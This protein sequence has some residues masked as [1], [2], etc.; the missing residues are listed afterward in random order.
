M[1]QI[2]S[3]VYATFI[4]KQIIPK[5]KIYLELCYLLKLSVYSFFF[6]FPSL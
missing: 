5:H 2:T 4:E 1:T 3:I 6:L